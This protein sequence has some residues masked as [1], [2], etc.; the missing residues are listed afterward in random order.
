MKRN[1][2]DWW[3]KRFT[4]EERN[5]RYQLLR[6]AGFS[7]AHARGY[8]DYTDARLWRVVLR[9]DYIRQ[10]GGEPPSEKELARVRK[11]LTGRTNPVASWHKTMKEKLRGSAKRARTKGLQKDFMTRAS[12]EFRSEIASRRHPVICPK[13]QKVIPNP[14]IDALV[15]GLG[16]GLGAVGVK[17]AI[18][19]AQRKDEK[20][21]LRRRL[22]PYRGPR[23]PRRRN[24]SVQT[25][26][27]ILSLAALLAIPAII[28]LILTRNQSLERRG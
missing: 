14:F 2:V 20:N 9:P 7:P 26:G 28:I 25:A 1:V 27:N 23:L 10:S 8:R 3:Q 22:T 19:Y 24:P 17:T 16:F 21:P 18:N 6:K 4:P 15:T 11:K 13:C 12:Q 5:E